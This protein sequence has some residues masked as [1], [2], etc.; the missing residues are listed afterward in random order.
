MT[1][2]RVLAA[3]A[4]MAVCGSAG[5]A[6]A[7]Q[8]ITNG[9]FSSNS[10]ENYDGDGVSATERYVGGGQDITGWTYNVPGGNGYN[11]GGLLTV[12]SGDNLNSD[13]N[14][15]DNAGH[16]G[17]WGSSN[18]G[19]STI[20]SAPGNPASVLA[21]DSAPENA[22]YLSQTVSG[23][24]IGK[25]YTLT[26]QWSGV[27]LYGAG[28]SLWNGAT[29]EGVEVNLGGTY[30]TSAAGGTQSQA[31]T[32]GQTD[33]VTYDDYAT[34]IPSHGFTGWLDASM[35]FTATAASE[36]LN[37]EGISTSS[38]NPPFVLIS[39]VSMFSVPEPASWA[40]MT[41]G[42][43]GVGLMARRRRALGTIA[44]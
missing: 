29:N 9:N 39:D 30:D 38:G 14:M 4:A 28:G 22:A 15:I 27:Q 21:Q 13:F 31:F 37:L 24:Q 36:V 1:Y 7:T 5:M 16:L 40:L 25:T 8:L 35:T 32:G 44:A 3:A 41:L 33:T 17:L 20:T 18:G 34:D 26:F 43:A 2:S 11:N 12:L 19:L 10:L 6:A 23:L 42:V